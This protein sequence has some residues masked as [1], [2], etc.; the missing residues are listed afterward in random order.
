MCLVVYD[1][2][3]FDLYCIL[4]IYWTGDYIG[5]SIAIFL[6]WF[7][8]MELGIFAPRKDPICSVPEKG[9][10]TPEK[11]NVST[12]QVGVNNNAFLDDTSP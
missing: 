7:Y 8:T 1:D 10:T 9:E 4:Q 11:T 3:L 2:A 6:Y 5:G 12:V